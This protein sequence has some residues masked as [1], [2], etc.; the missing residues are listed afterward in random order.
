VRLTRHLDLKLS[1]AC[2]NNCVHC[3]IA[4]QRDATLAQ[5]RRDFRTTAEVGRELAEAAA[6]GVTLVTFTGGEPTI[7]RDLPALVRAAIALGMSVGIQTNGRLL[8]RPEVRG[9]L[10]GHSVRFVVAVHGPDAVIH[11][12]I[13]RAPGAFGQTMDAVR[14]LVAAGEKVSGKVVISRYNAAV[15][16]RIADLLA[17]A[18]V[19]RA[20]FTFPHALGNAGRAFDEVVP[21]YAEVLPSLLAALDRMG[22]G[23]VTEAVPPCLL[24]R[25]AGRASE[26]AWRG[27]LSSEVRQLD[28]GPRDWTR[29]R[30]TEGKAKAA[31]CAGCALDASCEGVWRE[32][33][34]A[35]GGGEMRP[36]GP[37]AKR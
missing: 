10:L 3:V 8:S 1:Y 15:L 12:R 19:A 30:R 34:E 33:L 25:H 18:G 24:G 22:E 35:F 9:P 28:Q 21:R 27:T 11:D 5:G 37:D 17:E 14:A 6:R 20:S 13:T 31:A 36:V 16:D 26:A 4:D 29:D 23:G 7:R 32:Y 2:N